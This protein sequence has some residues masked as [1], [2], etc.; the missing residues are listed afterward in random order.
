MS[1]PSSSQPKDAHERFREKIIHGRDI[2]DM[3][4]ELNNVRNQTRT[5]TN[6]IKMKEEQILKYKIGLEKA[7]SI[8]K[9]MVQSTQRKMEKLQDDVNELQEAIKMK[10]AKIR[11]QN[12]EIISLNQKLKTGSRNKNSSSQEVLKLQQE[13]D[14]YKA[15]S[16]NAKGR[17]SNQ[18]RELHDNNIK[19]KEANH[20]LQAQLENIHNKHNR[21]IQE[22]R[23]KTQEIHRLVALVDDLQRLNHSGRGQYDDV[24]EN[25]RLTLDRLR[26]D[27]DGTERDLANKNAMIEDVAFFVNVKNGIDDFLAELNTEVESRIDLERE[28]VKIP[29]LVCPVTFKA[30]MEA[31][32][33]E[34]LPELG[35]KLNREVEEDQRNCRRALKE[36]QSKA[37][38]LLQSID[39]T[40]STLKNNKFQADQFNEIFGDI[41][42]SLEQIDDKVRSVSIFFDERDQMQGH[43]I[44]PGLSGFR[45]NETRGVLWQGYGN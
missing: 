35:A 45:I 15:N 18:E 22:D 34:D 32:T 43:E 4:E 25:S 37:Y 1:R 7:K 28:A 3:E 12:L 27:L 36:M 20:R 38:F 14:M 41:E 24:R 42:A 26:K 11:N 8:L 33:V 17:W 23:E 44:N 19:L 13:L 29:N 39:D 5:Q 40:Q 31:E 30:I 6:L 16:Q 9:D 21:K 2:S 10:E